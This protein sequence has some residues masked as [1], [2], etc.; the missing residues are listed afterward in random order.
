MKRPVVQFLAALL[1]VAASIA[2]W[3]W[4]FVVDP[5]ALPET[6]LATPLVGWV[7]APHEQHQVVIENG[8]PVLK[9][10]RSHPKDKAAG[11]RIW[12]GPLE[13]VRFIHV[14][15]ESRRK[16]VV[17]G[18]QP[19]LIARFIANMRDPEGVTKHPMGAF[20]C[21][22]LGSS[23]WKKSE[24]VIKL[25]SDM[26]D[27]GFAIAML[28]DSGTFELRKLS[29]VAVVQR[30]WVPAATVIVLL[31]GL[32]LFTS[33]IRS[34]SNR[35]PLTRSIV[36]AGVLVTATWILVFPQISGLLHPV[37]NTFSVGETSPPPPK[38]PKPATP[39]K[40]APPISKPANPPPKETPSPPPVATVPSTPTPE[41][42][43]PPEPKPRD[44]GWLYRTLREIDKRFGPAHLV[45]FTGLTLTVL[46]ITGQSSQW[47]LPLAIALLSEI[48]P[49]LVDRQGGWDDWID[50]ITNISGVGLA[51]L[52]WVRLPILK[53]LH[54]K[55]AN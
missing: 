46:I 52:L 3:H 55:A 54:Q 48:V 22:G 21:G 32:A 39:A 14:R 28:G 24:V 25:T 16:D 1:L 13:N 18:P 20:I 6:R 43:A 5:G 2:I 7:S 27:F 47:R 26:S 12:Y 36:A 40:P 23:D 9:L 53:R 8:E 38:A 10:Y 17:Q 11:V 45:L 4:R 41:I 33:L 19:W 51:V 42:T 44:S 49:E 37:P 50:V 29:V 31:G 34:H 35:P 15:C 30:P